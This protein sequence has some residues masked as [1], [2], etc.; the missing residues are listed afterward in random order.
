MSEVL[1]D[2]ERLER[3]VKSL[4]NMIRDKRSLNRLLN[5]E[6]ESSNEELRQC[7]IQAL[8]DWNMSPPL[9]GAVTLGNHPNKHLLLIGAA[10]QALTSAGIWHSRE[11]MPSSDGGTSADDHAKAAEYSGWISRYVE[12]YER[13]KGDLKTTL[14]IAAALGNMPVPSEYGMSGFSLYGELW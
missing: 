10:I 9:I 14:N 13:K 12:E 1:N 11:H 8:Q 2:Q 4:R 6:E 3:A 7:I 5:G